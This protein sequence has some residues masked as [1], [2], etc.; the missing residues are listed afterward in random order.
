MLWENKRKRLRKDNR[1]IEFQD[2]VIEEK[3]NEGHLADLE[4]DCYSDNV[5]GGPGQK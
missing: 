3:V 1:S 2:C 5:A 4:D